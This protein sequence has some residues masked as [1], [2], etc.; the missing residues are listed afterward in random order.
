MSL[1]LKAIAAIGAVGCPLSCSG[2]M[3]ASI[4]RGPLTPWTLHSK[5]TTLVAEV[6]PM[7]AEPTG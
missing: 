3:L 2:K 7:R 1:N 4:I 5:S 6:G